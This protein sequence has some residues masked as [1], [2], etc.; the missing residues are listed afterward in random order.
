LTQN[1]PAEFCKRWIITLVFKKNAKISE[2]CDHNID[3]RLLSRIAGFKKHEKN[4]E[5]TNSI[6]GKIC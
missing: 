6:K 1:N 2:N 5:L 4:S 3:P